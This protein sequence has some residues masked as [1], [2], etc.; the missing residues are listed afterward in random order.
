MTGLGQEKLN[1]FI[2]AYNMGKS[3]GYFDLKID[4]IVKDSCV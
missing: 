4:E 1:Q 2:K 3:L